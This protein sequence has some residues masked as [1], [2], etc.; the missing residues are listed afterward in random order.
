ML[1]MLYETDSNLGSAQVTVIVMLEGERDVLTRD[2]L[3]KRLSAQENFHVVVV[4]NMIVAKALLDVIVW[5]SRAL[6]SNV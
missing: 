4:L 1:A 5:P 3:H 6:S 2:G